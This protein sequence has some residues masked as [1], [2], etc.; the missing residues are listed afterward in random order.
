[1]TLLLI[2]AYLAC[3]VAVYGWAVALEPL[4]YG[5]ERTWLDLLVSAT[6]AVIWP[7]S[8]PLICLAGRMHSMPLWCGWRL[9]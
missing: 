5:Y 6:A 9:R 7:L 2:L 1:M 4:D 8:A 3:A